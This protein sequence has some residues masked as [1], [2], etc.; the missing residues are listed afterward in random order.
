MIRKAVTAFLAGGP[1]EEQR[2]GESVINKRHARLL[3]TQHVLTCHFFLAI[4]SMCI[5][6]KEILY[7]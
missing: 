7:I 4:H 1:C 5:V 3:V 6:F 2:A